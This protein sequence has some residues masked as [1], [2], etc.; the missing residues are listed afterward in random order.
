MNGITLYSILASVIITLLQ[1][2]P[3]ETDSI[4]LIEHKNNSLLVNHHQF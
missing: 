1:S 4:A 2:P 3:S